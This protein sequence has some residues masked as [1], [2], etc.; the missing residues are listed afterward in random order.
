MGGG[1]CHFLKQIM[2]EVGGPTLGHEAPTQL[3]NI[4]PATFIL[5]E[6]CHN[7]E[8][9]RCAPPVVGSFPGP[10]GHPVKHGDVRSSS[11][12]GRR[13]FALRRRREGKDLELGGGEPAEP[14]GAKRR[15]SGRERVRPGRRR[16]VRD[17]VGSHLI[18]R[19]CRHASCIRLKTSSEVHQRKQASFIC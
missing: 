4:L 2:E 5:R 15:S 11:Y 1:G 19:F 14:N 12:L 8:R 3:C 17:R 10:L 13:R 7:S 18:P 6:I 9:A 16:T